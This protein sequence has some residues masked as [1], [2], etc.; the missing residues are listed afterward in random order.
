MDHNSVH[1]LSMIISTDLDWAVVPSHYPD[2][3]YSSTEFCIW[4]RAKKTDTAFG[5][6]SFKVESVTCEGWQRRQMSTSQKDQI[7]QCYLLSQ[8]HVIHIPP[9]NIYHLATVAIFHFTKY[10]YLCL[11]RAW[12]FSMLLLIAI[13]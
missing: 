10:V 5:D 1:S 13:S 9:V 12:R 11:H 4:K 2:S 7:K 3:R 8:A 6:N